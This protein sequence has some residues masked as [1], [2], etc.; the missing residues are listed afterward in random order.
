LFYRQ[1]AAEL[2]DAVGRLG[3][4]AREAGDRD[5]YDFRQA[6]QGYWGRRHGPEFDEFERFVCRWSEHIERARLTPFAWQPDPKSQPWLAWSPA[7]YALLCTCDE[8]V[9]PILDPDDDQSVELHPDKFR[10]LAGALR[11]FPGTLANECIYELNRLD[12]TQRD[13]QAPRLGGAGADAAT[14]PRQ[15]NATDRQI[16]AHCRRKGHTGER[17][18]HHLGLSYDHVRRVLARLVKEKRLR[19]TED[20]YRTVRRAT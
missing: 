3:R 7:L 18:A 5:T 20:G 4:E 2:A 10:Q 1:Y 11:R 9:D 17:I 8:I 13:A 12:S 14:A 6:L 15:P 19:V 16:L